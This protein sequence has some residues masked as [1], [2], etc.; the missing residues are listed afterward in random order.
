MDSI[1]CYVATHSDS[2]KHYVGITGRDLA[3]RRSEHEK[4]A[5]KNSSDTPFHKVIRNYGKDAFTWKIAATGEEEVIKLLE[6]VLIEGWRTNGLG[7]FNAIG[8]YALP[9]VRDLELDRLFEEHERDTE[10]LHT[11][12]DLVSIV[13]YCEENDIS[14]DRLKD[15]RELGAR[16]L[17]RA[18]QLDPN[19]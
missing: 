14:P 9:P 6:H 19:V 12:N 1:I 7:G 8:G 16:L 18:D 13:S 2:G 4:D 10:F 3:T 5:V 11:L 17:N 15:L